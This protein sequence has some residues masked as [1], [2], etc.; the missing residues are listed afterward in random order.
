MFTAAQQQQKLEPTTTLTTT[1]KESTNISSLISL[2]NDNL[3]LN[4][5]NNNNKVHSTLFNSNLIQMQQ[6][7][8][9][10]NQLVLAACSSFTNQKSKQII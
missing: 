2:E 7:M 3:Y 5:N 8:F 1:I 6:N 9:L 10:L 4:T